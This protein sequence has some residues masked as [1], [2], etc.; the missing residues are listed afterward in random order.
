MQ[1]AKKIIHL[2][3]AA[4][5]NFMKVSP[6]YHAL[7]K[8]SWVD[9]FIIHTGQHYDLNMSDSFFRDLRLPEPHSHLEV[10][11]GTH[12]EQTGRVII[13]YEKAVVEQGEEKVI[14]EN[15]RYPGPKPT[16]KET[17]LLMIADACESAVRAMIEP[18][19]EKIENVVTNIISARL[20]D[21]QLE[22]APL[23]FADLRKINS[24]FCSTLVALHHK[25]IRYPLQDELESE[26]KDDSGE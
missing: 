5:P 13:G 6:L 23:T 22:E 7:K 8:E 26:S 24:S 14:I 12:A 1:S 16:S 11:S 9:T 2:I 20:K 21:G 17:A 25:R 18:T 3:A 19:P 15:Y 4:R 10:G